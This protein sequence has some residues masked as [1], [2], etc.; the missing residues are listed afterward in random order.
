MKNLHNLL[1]PFQIVGF[2]VS[3]IISIA[4]IVS[5][6]DQINS[7][8]LGLILATL[9]QLFDLQMRQNA[10]EERLI[11]ANALSRILY[12][13]DWLLKNIRQIIVDYKQV[14][15]VWFEPFH[16]RAKETIIQCRDTL[17]NMAEGYAFT[18]PRF[19]TD[20]STIAFKMAKNELK[21]VDSGEFDFWKNV[22]A[23]K[24]VELNAAV[25]KKGVTVKRIFIIPMDTVHENKDIF[26][27]QT[28]LGIDVYVVSQVRFPRN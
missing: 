8:I 23:E 11:A 13:D 5:G 16:S 1:H 4:L 6:Q 20:E 28:E 15:C 9:I 19:P 3:S 27:K 26:K 24:Y 18:Q 10:S 2:V 17:H 14:E 21:A 25:V 22:Y 12:R 7:V